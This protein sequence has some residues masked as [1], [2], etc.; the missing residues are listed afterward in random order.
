MV[1]EAPGL[2]GEKLMAQLSAG[3]RSLVIH[4]MDKRKNA[5]ANHRVLILWILRFA[6][7]LLDVKSAP[8]LLSIWG[9]KV[10]VMPVGIVTVEINGEHNVAVFIVK[11]KCTI[12]AAQ[13][14]V[15]NAKKAFV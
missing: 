5:C 6:H 12:T 4:I 15:E 9:W 7:F 11:K 3:T 1:M 2:T 8:Q 13:V 14:F 10:L